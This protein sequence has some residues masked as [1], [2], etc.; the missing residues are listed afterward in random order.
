MYNLMF[1]QRGYKDFYLLG[2][3]ARISGNKNEGQL[4]FKNTCHL[5][6]TVV[7]RILILSICFCKGFSYKPSMN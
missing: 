5:F 4:D 3:F 2:Q 6:V 7:G 1:S